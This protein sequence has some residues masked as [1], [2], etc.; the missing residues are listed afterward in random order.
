MI[1]FF[2]STYGMKETGVR[3]FFL[4]FKARKCDIRISSVLRYEWFNT[5]QALI[6]KYTF[7]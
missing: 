4:E 2:A 7:R 1:Q 6:S 5:E 3:Y